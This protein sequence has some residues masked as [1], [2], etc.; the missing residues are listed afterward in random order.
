MRQVERSLANSEQDT[1]DFI[2]RFSVTAEDTPDSTA[3]VSIQVTKR[4]ADVD[5]IFLVDNA[6]QSMFGGSVSILR[7]VLASGYQRKMALAFTHT[8]QVSGPNLP[9][10]ASRRA[11]V[12]R[13]ASRRNAID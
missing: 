2:G 13:S 5:A 10:F 6:T 8:D 1:R 11:H 3:S 12:L 7:S 4:Y 9:D